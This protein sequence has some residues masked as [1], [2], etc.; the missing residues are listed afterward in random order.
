MKKELEIQTQADLAKKLGAVDANGG[1]DHKALYNLTGLL[2]DKH[3][4]QH[5]LALFGGK[6]IPKGVI[7]LAH[8]YHG[9][10]DSGK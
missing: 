10:F 4:P 8:S 3:P 9:A 6:A 5:L 7:N 1:I 2:T